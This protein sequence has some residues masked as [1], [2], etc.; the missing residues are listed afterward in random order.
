M[1]EIVK[2]SKAIPGPSVYNKTTFDEKYVK[3]PKVCYKQNAE[4]YSYADEII[5]VEKKKVL[6]YDPITLDKIKNRTIQW[7]IRSETEKEQEVKNRKH[8]K[9]DSPS[10]T[11]YNKGE[12]MDRSSVF[13]NTGVNFKIS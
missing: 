5:Y 7:K 2:K 8:A 9:N 1:Q 13:N 10:P 3:P 12:A 4:K 6:H 11:S